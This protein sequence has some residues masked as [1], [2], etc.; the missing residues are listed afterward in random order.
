M[1]GPSIAKPVSSQDNRA[2][3]KRDNRPE[4]LPRARLVPTIPELSHPP[5]RTERSSFCS[6]IYW[7]TPQKNV[8][9]YMR[10][11]Q[12]L[13]KML[14]DAILTLYFIHL[15]KQGSLCLRQSPWCSFYKTVQL[16]H[17]CSVEWHYGT[18]GV[19]SFCIRRIVFIVSNRTSR[20]MLYDISCLYLII[21][22]GD[23]TGGDSGPIDYLY[24]ANIFH[25]VS[26]RT[27]LIFTEEC[28]LYVL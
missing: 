10:H 4:F 1:V 6:A 8:L 9:K 2:Q 19:N 17:L 5:H 3:N 28:K 18:C 22:R 25:S 24:S 21:Q 23:H 14:I 11:V 13:G 27:L 12:K 7:K 20:R 15:M 16:Q 26:Y